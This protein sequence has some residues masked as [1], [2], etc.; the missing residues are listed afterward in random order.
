Y[1]PIFYQAVRHH[2][3]TKSG[4]DLL[5]FLLGVISTV[6]SSGIIV[7]KV[8]YYWHF[9][10]CAPIFLA[11]G[12]GLLYTLSTSTSSAKIV[13]FQIL[14]GMGTGMGMQNAILAIQVEFKDKPKLLAQATS[15]ASFAQF[16]GGTIGL[17]VAEPV[18]SSELGKYLLRYAPEAPAEIVRESPTAIYSELP[19]AMI[20]GVVQAYMQSLRVVFLLGVPV[21][22]LA[23]LASMVIQNIKI[24]KTVPA[25]VAPAKENG[26]AEKGGEVETGAV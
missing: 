1:I 14:V 26:D 23:L 5:P 16:L 2:S 17:G 10:V 9:L 15:V 12:S 3:A 6:I 20:P 13:G 21:A 25:D 22:G 24:E 19:A 4:V 8:G 7:G 18:F 11:V